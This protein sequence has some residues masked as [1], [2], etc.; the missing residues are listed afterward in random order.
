MSFVL[1]LKLCN[2]KYLDNYQNLLKFELNHFI[3]RIFDIL[4]TTLIRSMTFCY[5]TIYKN[6][7]AYLCI[8]TDFVGYE[9]YI[10]IQKIG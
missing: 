3:N 9:N 5:L 7:S 1:T 2:Q 6:Y 4:G 8:N 10:I